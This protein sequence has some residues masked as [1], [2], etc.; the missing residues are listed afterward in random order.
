M[1]ARSGGAQGAGAPAQADR[2]PG[3]GFADDQR[4]TLVRALAGQLEISLSKAERALNKVALTAARELLEGRSVELPGLATLRL[5]DRPA[6]VGKDPGTGQP[7][8]TPASTTLT[9][10]PIAPFADTLAKRTAATIVLAVPQSDTFSKVLAFHFSHAGWRI[11]LVNS[12][13]ECLNHLQQQGTN[14]AIVDQGLPRAAALI[15]EIKCDPEVGRVP[16]IALFPSHRDPASEGGFALLPDE[17][18]IEPFEVFTLITLAESELRRAEASTRDLINLPMHSVRMRLGNEEGDLERGASV[19]TRLLEGAELGEE[20]QV[21]LTAVFREAVGNAAQHGNRDL[22]TGRIFVT[23]ER[24]LD[25]LVLTVRDEGAG[26]DHRRELEKCVKQT[27]VDAA[28][29]RHA[30]GRTGGLGIMVIQRCTDKL[31][32]NELGNELKMTKYL[33]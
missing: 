30:E 13:E 10:E 1:N 32:F 12:A 27:A 18:L 9:A 16:V 28:R 25:R 2:K 33:R 20:T 3:S 31:E 21:A 6:E 17:K 26:F 15:E 29:A 8:I 23:Y 24:F 22:V 4:D 19:F 14:L 11:D 7:R 5:V